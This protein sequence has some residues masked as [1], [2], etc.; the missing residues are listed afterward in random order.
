M[1]VQPSVLQNA[2]G[3]AWVWTEVSPSSNA[4]TPVT[5]LRLV[6]FMVPSFKNLISSMGDVTA[7]IRLSL[8]PLF[9]CFR[10]D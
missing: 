5:S 4:P 10:F 1:A 6:N 8:N 7:G 9:H 2:K 3:A